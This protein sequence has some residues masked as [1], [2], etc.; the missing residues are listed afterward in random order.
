MDKTYYL[1]HGGKTYID[2]NDFGIT[3]RR[4]GMLNAMNQGL[5][6]DKTIPF[7]SIAA[8]QLKKPGLTNG[9]IQ[10]SVLGGNE[11]RG[12]VLA[13]T[14]DE[15][16]VM[17]AGKKEYAEM[18]ELKNI[19]EEKI[20]LASSSSSS[21]STAD[22]LRKFKELLEDGILTQEEFDAKKKDLLGL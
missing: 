2:L 14:Q 8:V 13:A 20:R 15:N 17:F 1:K 21:V 11:S 3:I 4:K 22:E 19:V 16:T 7:T 12:G 5:K 10:F 6:G 9:Y 18:T